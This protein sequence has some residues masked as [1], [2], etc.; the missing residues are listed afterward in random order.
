MDTRRRA[1]KFINPG[2][3]DPSVLYLQKQHISEAVWQGHPD[4]VLHARRHASIN[5][6]YPPEAL[7]R[8]LRMAGFYGASRAGYFPY[9]H[10][11]VSA[12]VER[13]RPETHT[14]HMPMGECTITLQDVAVQLGLPIEGMPVI[15]STNHNWPQLCEECFGLR[16]GPTDIKG[17]RLRMNWL[18]EN[19]DD[20]RIPKEATDVQ[21][22][23]FTR[24]YIMRII[25]GFLMPDTSGNWVQLIYLP[26]LQD[27]S[28]AGKY[29]WGSAVLAFMYREMCTAI[30]YDQVNIGGCMHLLHVWVWDRFPMLAPRVEGRHPRRLS[31]EEELQLYPIHPPLGYRW[32]DYKGSKSF[33]MHMVSWYRKIIDQMI[34]TDPDRVLR[35]F[36]Q[37]QPI[38]LDAVDMDVDH[39]HKLTGKTEMHWPT[40]QLRYLEIWEQRF[41]RVITTPIACD[42]PLGHNSIYM[43]W[44][45]RI[46]RKWIDPDGAAFAVAANAFQFIFLAC[47]EGPERLSDIRNLCK[48]MMQ[49]VYRVS[50]ISRGVDDVLPP[51]PP[52]QPMYHPST[53]EQGP[54]RKK[55]KG[56]RKT[57][58]KVARLLD[59]DDDDDHGDDNAGDTFDTGV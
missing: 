29:S 47:D 19:F 44:Y 20:N 25:G 52:P 51:P 34:D 17:Q 43:Q 8:Y 18:D 1:A 46:T 54:P 48:N 38:P 22:Q 59:S 33:P 30:R 31:D 37:Q 32:T 9:D 5:D 56:F 53:R 4:R 7:V 35:Q 2:P 16:P 42:E 28:Q 10:H 41:H 39:T 21:L 55:A 27:L 40:E 36:G 50:H 49:T 23:Q 13:W 15:G 45:L 26:L 11:L 3:E 14:F 57:L 12:F 24:A 6:H 58:P